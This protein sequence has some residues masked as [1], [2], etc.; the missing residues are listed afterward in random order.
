MGGN[1]GFEFRYAEGQPDRLPALAADLGPAKRRRSSSISAG[2]GPPTRTEGDL[3]TIPIVMVSR[4]RPIAAGLRCRLR[5]TRSNI[6]EP[7]FFSSTE[8]T[9]KRLQLLGDPPT[10]CARRRS[11]GVPP[12][13]S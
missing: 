8:L 11:S 3:K 4:Q 7:A 10:Y 12:M 5:T 2:T 1:V 13:S 6:T 9:A